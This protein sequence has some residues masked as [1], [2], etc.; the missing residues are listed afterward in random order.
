[1]ADQ[2]HKRNHKKMIISIIFV[3]I[4]IPVL[5]ILASSGLTTTHYSYESTRVS[6]DLDGLTIV[7]L[8]DIHCKNFG[9]NNEKLIDAINRLEP[10]IIL[11]TGDSI[12]IHHQDLTPLENL[13]AGIC[14]TAPVYAISG[15][16]ECVD[17]DLYAQLIALYNK[18]GITDLDDKEIIFTYGSDS[19]SIKGIGAFENKNRWDNEFMLNKS[20]E[21]LSIL[22][23]HYPL[24]DELGVFGY[25]MILSGHIHGGI[26]RLPILGG[27][28]GNDRT[29]FPEYDSGQYTYARTTMYVSRGI[30]D[31]VIPRINNNPEIVCITLRHK[32]VTHND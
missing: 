24:L 32:D 20:P 7:H 31:T 16:H 14:R 13:F 1:M 26:I 28:F 25:D 18:Y 3:L 29:L 2:K 17:A 9:R 30:G 12:D 6:K 5:L 10:D 19:I 11:I 21:M 4:F 27:L 23:D 8:S 22:L 15:N